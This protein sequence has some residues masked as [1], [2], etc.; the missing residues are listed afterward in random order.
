MINLAVLIYS[1]VRI[2]I[3]RILTVHPQSAFNINELSRAAGFSPR[4]VERELKNLHAGGIL[5]KEI[6]GNQHRFQLD[7]VCP[8]YAEIRTLIVKT[9]GVAG[10]LQDALKPYEKDITSAFVFG[11]FATADYGSESEI[12][13]FIVSG[14]SSPDLETI[15]DPARERTGRAISITHF[16]PNEFSWRKSLNDQI[17]IPVIEGPKIEIISDISKM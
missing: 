15:L 14:L 1:K 16:T 17:L 10:V 3:L 13:L 6:A 12:E 11:A 5:K 9:N 8:V 4:G 2:E 7:P